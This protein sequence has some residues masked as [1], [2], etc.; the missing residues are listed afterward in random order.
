MTNPESVQPQQL[1][2]KHP[3]A[4]A[5]E[6]C[7]H[8]DKPICEYCLS[9][10][11][12]LF[13]CRDC[14]RA[15]RRK[16]RFVK[17]G[18]A[19]GVLALVGGIGYL[20]SGALKTADTEKIAKGQRHG[21]VSLAEQLRERIAKDPC[22]RKIILEWVTQEGAP[23]DQILAR[24]KWFYD[25]CEPWVRLRWETY[26]CHKRDGRWDEAIREVSRI[27]AVHPFDKDF[28]WWRG[29]LYYRK[30]D[31]DRSLR[32]YWQSVMM[33]PTLQVI[34][35][36]LARVA[37]WAGKPCRGVFPMLQHEHYH[38]DWN[39]DDDD[40]AFRK[41]YTRTAC[42]ETLGTGVAQGP[43]AA[44][45]EAPPVEARINDRAF[46][47][48]ALDLDTGL[49]LISRS[50]A[51]K[52]GLPQPPAGEEPFLAWYGDRWQS[53]QF[54]IL[55]E[56]RWDKARAKQVEAL[57]I[58]SPP[59]FTDGVLGRT[60]L[61]RFAGRFNADRTT[62]SLQPRPTRDATPT[63]SMGAIPADER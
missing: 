52:L 42:P 53:G 28:R 35:F 26:A 1:C 40:L 47:H 16:G 15:V 48:F 30:K 41:K 44:G 19:I 60:F 10:V 45:W 43:L 24:V 9:P 11:G 58:D 5:E 25:R 57:V 39:L 32:D 8:C 4:M 38:A 59:F 62:V 3:H 18:I 46:G 27:I 17:I 29:E 61:L 49:T 63:P 51:N 50:L 33:R 37:K 2:H 7:P 31:W 21:P 14:A 13:L 36:E 20:A 56:V 34:P 55:K 12:G 6:I 22:N 54:V 23:C